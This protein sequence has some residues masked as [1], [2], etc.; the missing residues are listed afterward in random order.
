M[1]VWGS[2]GNVITLGK[3]DTQYCPICEHQ[4]DFF[5]TT[6][7][8]NAHIFWI[9]IFSWGTKFYYHCSICDYGFKADNR[10]LKPY[11]YRN[12]KPALHRFGWLLVI[13]I[14]AIIV[15][16]LVSPQWESGETISIAISI[17]L[18][19]L[20]FTALFYFVRNRIIEGR[21][22]SEINPY[23]LYPQIQSAKALG[24][25]YCSECGAKIGET[26]NFCPDCGFNLAGGVSIAVDIEA[27]AAK[28]HRTLAL[29]HKLKEEWDNAIAE[30]TKAI[31]SDTNFTL[32]YFERGELHKRLG[33]KSE[34]ITDFEK[35][36]SLSNK[37]ATV[38]AAKEYIE[39][40]QK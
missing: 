23:E 38:E 18:F 21:K 12:P 27:T 13:A 16:L 7:Y 36:V 6:A 3:V 1:I 25:R 31:E 22:R 26:A 28:E 5:L 9:P 11:L 30:Y 4:R 19:I 14:I 29:N 10:E 2:K 15:L 17:I 24:S 35:V 37:P 33:K 20:L 39:E 40:L 34:A 32:A 8:N